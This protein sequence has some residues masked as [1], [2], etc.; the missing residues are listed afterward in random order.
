MELNKW[1]NLWAS[2]NSVRPAPG[3]VISKFLAAGVGVG[4]GVS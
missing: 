4:V 2:E 3:R 1:H